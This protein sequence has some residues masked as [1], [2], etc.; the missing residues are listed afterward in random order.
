MHSC[1]FAP[2]TVEPFSVPGFSAGPRQELGPL[3]LGR[4]AAS[5]SSLHATC[6]EEFVRGRTYFSPFEFFQV[7]CVF[8]GHGCGSLRDPRDEYLL[9]HAQERNQ[10]APSSFQ[11]SRYAAAYLLSYS[12]YVL[13]VFYDMFC[14]ARRSQLLTGSRSRSSRSRARIITVGTRYHIK[15][16]IVCNSCGNLFRGD[17]TLLIIQPS[18]D[19]K[20]TQARQWQ[21][22]ETMSDVV[23]DSAMPGKDEAFAICTAGAAGGHLTV[24]C[25]YIFRRCTT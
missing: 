20:N 11:S 5:G 2:K 25:E 19:E 13:G 3:G 17:T 8:L 12:P 23:G 24:P 21:A 1:R 15:Y 7:H 10:R 4:T 6:I 14:S 16:E 9:G 22:T 18:H